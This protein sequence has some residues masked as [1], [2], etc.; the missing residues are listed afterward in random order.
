MDFSKAPN[1]VID[2]IVNSNDEGDYQKQ[3]VP[4]PKL[5]KLI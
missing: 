3:L 2:E 5:G 4:F 1:E